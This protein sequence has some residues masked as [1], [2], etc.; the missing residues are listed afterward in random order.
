MRSVRRISAL[1]TAS[2]VAVL[3]GGCYRGYKSPK[4]LEADGR[5]P[6]ACSK[7]CQELGLQMS[8]FV[9]VEHG[10]SGCV[11]SP[12]G[13]PPPSGPAAAAAAGHVMMQQQQE[14]QQT[15]MA[16]PPPGAY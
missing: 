1:A 2:I 16:S 3:L 14:Q 15:Q 13:A 7:S 6:T 10:M 12:P 9:L 8:A 4:D 11:C 5:G